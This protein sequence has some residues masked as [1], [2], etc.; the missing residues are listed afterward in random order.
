M[1]SPQLNTLII[2]I[3]TKITQFNNNKNI[4]ELDIN[5]INIEKYDDLITG[6]NKEFSDFIA[7][8]P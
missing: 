8:A 5:T 3:S 6:L 4:N 7:I 2:N 1:L